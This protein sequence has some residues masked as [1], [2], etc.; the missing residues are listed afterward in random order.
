MQKSSNECVSFG[1]IECTRD[2]DQT[3][4]SET[5]R[6]CIRIE[7]TLSGDGADAAVAAARPEPQQSPP[8]RT[9]PTPPP[10]TSP[11][12][13]SPSPPSSAPRARSCRRC[14]ARRSRTASPRL[15]RQRC[16][17]LARCASRERV[18]D[19]DSRFYV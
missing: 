15:A 9:T 18:S 16:S 12:P 2:L 1:A 11:S 8:S 6:A 13:T 17:K 10:P 7:R 3:C 4:S 5:R 19:A 14:S